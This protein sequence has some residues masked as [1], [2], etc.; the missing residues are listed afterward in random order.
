MGLPV[1]NRQVS[2][3][4]LR[5]ETRPRSGQAAVRRASSSA[6]IF[7]PGREP[8]NCSKKVWNRDQDCRGSSRRAHKTGILP[9]DPQPPMV[10]EAEVSEATSPQPGRAWLDYAAQRS[11]DA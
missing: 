5:A 8:W 3:T 4:Q 11:Q 9:L 6:P 10:S 1:G 7:V 2:Q